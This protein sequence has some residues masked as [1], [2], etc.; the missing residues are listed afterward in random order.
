MQNNNNVTET[1]EEQTIEIKN[2][3]RDVELKKQNN[4]KLQ[5]EILQ[6]KTP[7]TNK[8]QEKQNPTVFNLKEKPH[9]VQ[10]VST[11]TQ[12]INKSK[13]KINSGWQIIYN[14]IVGIKLYLFKY[15]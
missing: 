1:Q 13:N 12:L 8:Q 5:Q 7:R 9:R 4:Y 2:V 3:T 11:V 15:L 10:Y 14:K 6:Q